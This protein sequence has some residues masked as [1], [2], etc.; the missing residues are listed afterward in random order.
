MVK[1]IP[2]TLKG[3]RD[4]GPSESGARA[5][6]FEKVRVVFERYG[7]LPMETPA[8]EYKEILAGK[9]GGEG[10]KLMYQFK[11][12][13]GRDVAMRYDL[14]VPL[15]R[16][17]AQYQNDLAIPF[18]R[19]QIAPVWR[20]D[21]PQKG[22]FREFT[23]CDIDVVGSNSLFA[24]AEVMA[25]VNAALKEL[26]IPEVLIKINNRK[27]LDGL[28][29]EAGIETKKAANAIRILDKLEKTGEDGIRGELASIGIQTKQV[30]KLLEVLSADLQDTKDF[31]SKFRDFEGAG[32]L[33]EVLEILL[34]MGVKNYQ[35]DLTLARG[36]DYYTGSIF[37]FVLPDA[38]EFGSIAGG[39]RYDNLIGLLNS[40]FPSL[41]KRGAR[42]GVPAVGCSIGIDRLLDAL[43]E[44]ELI[45]YDLVSDVLVCNLDEKL[46]DKYLKVVQELRAAG[47]KTDFYYPPAGRAGEPA[48]L[49]KQLKYADKKNIN[50][51]VLIGEKEEKEGA[52]TVKN[53]A[54]GKQE[55]IKQKDLIK[56]LQK[57]SSS[58][59]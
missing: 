5:Q 16:F 53:L 17:F 39:G 11:D 9:Y 44:L 37:E 6:I 36:L 24:D 8:L 43:E 52:V 41:Q 57:E 13:G 27:F 38:R 40:P 54:T 59:T 33:A 20:A 19:Y 12:Q 42:G 21:R 15:A 26:G 49:D 28:M 58:R 32:E 7:F 46:T 23:Q 34:D 10:E 35:V 18:K 25:C 1:I 45:K 3:F 55:M 31:I 14:T 50:F 2:Q 48:K 51:A 22:R 29:K 47:I 30:D 4:F 56:I